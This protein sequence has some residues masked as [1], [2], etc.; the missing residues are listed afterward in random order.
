MYTDKIR[1]AFEKIGYEGTAQINQAKFSEILA[2]LMVDVALSSQRS[3]DKPTTK[4]WRMSYGNRLQEGRTT[5]RS[6]RSARPLTMAST[7]S[8][9]SWMRSTVTHPPCR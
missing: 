3:P 4:T 6:T 7:F 2:N 8:R 1:E 9:A 5:S